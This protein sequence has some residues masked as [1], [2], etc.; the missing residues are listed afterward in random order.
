MLNLSG[1]RVNPH[2]RGLWI[3]GPAFVLSAALAGGVLAADK[4][5]KSSTKSAVRSKVSSP[6]RP[7]SSAPDTEDSEAESNSDVDGDLSALVVP[8]AT[9][10]DV[11][12]VN[13]MQF[14]Q[15]LRGLLLEGMTADGA[16]ASKRHFEAAHQNIPD[17]PRPAYVFD[18]AVKP[19][20]VAVDF[21][22]PFENLAW[23]RDRLVESG[24]IPKTEIARMIDADLR[25]QA[26]QRI[27]K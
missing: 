18:E 23:M 5:D 24:Q 26:I 15:A 17:D 7:D 20:V 9:L 4:P 21:P 13:Q 8:K 27:G 25:R 2:Q 19:G 22:I 1:H 6:A 16:A 11:K 10:G 3:V 12:R 14:S